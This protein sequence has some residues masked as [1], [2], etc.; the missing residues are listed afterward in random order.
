MW[1][2]LSS[3]EM[4][5]VFEGTQRMFAYLYGRP[6]QYAFYA[7]VAIVVGSFAYHVV[8]L[9][10]HSIVYFTAWG[11]SWS[12]EPDALQSAHG[13]VAAVGVA[14]IGTLN[15]LVIAVAEAFR[16]AFLFTATGILYLLI[17]RDN[18]QIEFDNVHA[19]GEQQRFDLPPLA[20]D[21]PAAADTGKTNS[22]HA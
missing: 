10:A 2:A 1:G 22:D 16:Y 13:G 7:V 11:V 3:E 4:G 17:R 12:G 21:E 9:L 18:D 8:S 14:I 20:T 6:L 5:D 19:P 15:S